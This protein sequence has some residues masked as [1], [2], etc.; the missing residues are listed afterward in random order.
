MWT[1]FI[2]SIGLESVKVD[3]ILH[4]KQAALGD[5]VKGEVLILGRQTE[6]SIEKVKVL[7][8]L[9]YE[10]VH[11]DSDFSWHDKHF[12]EVTLN[13][14]RN[15]TEGEEERIPFSIKIPEEGPKTDEKHK[16]ILQTQVVIP[17]A[18]DPKDED[19]LIIM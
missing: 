12:E 1:K 16:W 2:S 14:G 15:L 9:Q 18:F 13:V 8:Y 4:D 3:T 10:E 6:K 19:E 7:L 5:T 17:Q 11:P